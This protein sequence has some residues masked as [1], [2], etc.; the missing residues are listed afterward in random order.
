MDQLEEI[1]RKIDIVEF[2]N[3]FIPLKKT[4]RNFKALCPFHSEKTPSFIVSPERQIWHCFGQCSEG[5]DIFKFLMKIENLEFGEAV[6]EL[7]KRA[8]IKLTQYQPSEGEKNKQLLY[9]INHLAAEFYHF[10]LLNHPVGKKALDYI[11]G[12]GIKKESLALFK[13]GFAP[14]A[15]RSL[16]AFLVKKKG[17]RPEVLEKAG[18]VIKTQKG[19]FY[20]RFRHRLMFPLKD[21]HGNV[22]GF[23]GRLLDPQAKEAKYVNTPETFIYHKSDLLYGFFEAKKEIKEQDQAVLVEGELDM[24]SSYQTG[25]KNV[26]AIKGTALTENQVKLI[27]RFTQKIILALDQ[28]IAGDQ[29]AHRGIE[30]AENEGMMIRV[31]KL[32]GGKDPDEIAQKKPKLWWEL[33]KKAVPVYDYLIDSAFA[34]FNGEGIEGKRKI[35]EEIIPILA[36]IGNEIV[37]D[38]YLRQLAEK[39]KVSEEAI[40]REIGKARVNQAGVSPGQALFGKTTVVKEK[41]RREVLEEYLLS[42]GF[43]SGHWDLLRKRHVLGLVKTHRLVRILETLKD[44]FKHTQKPH[45][46]KLAKKLDPELLEGFNFFYLTD[47]GGLLEDE[48]KFQ[49]EFQ[50]TLSRLEKLDLQEQLGT[51]SGKIKELEKE[52]KLSPEQKQ[53]LKQSNEEFRDLSS[54]LKNFEKEE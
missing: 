37:R 38:H 19:D 52:K 45:S 20:D 8:G 42:L 33:I 22:R 5:G 21:H 6:K 7:A 40:G 36:R 34:R 46:E 51:L 43:Q 3:S 17:Y 48:E 16:Q 44:Y 13:I 54:K 12:R 53:K 47:L 10:L 50:K 4:G 41:S 18:L 30:M 24:I 9:E 39:L 27:S 25:V 28:D 32:Q 23:A 35:S 49:K 26:L 2:I 29:A 1:K 11:L 31:A 15:W 14:Q